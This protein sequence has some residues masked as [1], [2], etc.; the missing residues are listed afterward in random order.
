M[1]AK[2]GIAADE[3]LTQARDGMEARRVKEVWGGIICE[4]YLSRHN[5]YY[6]IQ[7]CA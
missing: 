4:W 7:N 5:F 3:E 2:G 1:E 6:E